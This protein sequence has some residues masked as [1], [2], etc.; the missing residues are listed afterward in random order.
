MARSFPE[1]ARQIEHTRFRRTR[2]DPAY[3]G[4]EMVDNL[5]MVDNFDLLQSPLGMVHH[6]GHGTTSHTRGAQVTAEETPFLGEKTLPGTVTV[7]GE[8]VP[9]DDVPGM[10]KRPGRQ[11]L[12]TGLGCRGVSRVAQT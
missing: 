11:P 8:D 3:G 6:S 4:A 5:E 2:E 7:C 1:Q 9:D 10:P 12:R